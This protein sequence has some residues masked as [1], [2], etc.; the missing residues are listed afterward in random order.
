MSS[1]TPKKSGRKS[2]GSNKTNGLVSSRTSSVRRNVTLDDYP[3]IQVEGGLFTIEHVR[4]VAK[5]EAEKQFS[6]DYEL[7]AGID[8]KEEIGRGFRIASTLWGE[9]DSARQGPGDKSQAT[10]RFVTQIL[11]D[12][13]GFTDVKETQP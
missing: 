1:E 2:A 10:I 9:F 12:C 7:P 6:T 4:K 5:V 8:I 13:F 3:A 11:K